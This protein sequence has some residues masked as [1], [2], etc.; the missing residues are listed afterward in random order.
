MSVRI[1]GL[2][3]LSAVA[4]AVSAADSPQSLWADGQNYVIERVILEKSDVFD[5]ADPEQDKWLYRLANRLHIITRDDTIMDQLLF[6]PGG[7]LDKR[8]LDESERILRTNKYLYD[9]NITVEKASGDTV[10]VRVHTRD[11]WSLQPE[12]SVSR[13]GGKTRTRF[14]LAETNLLGRGQQLRLLRDND[15]DRSENAIEFIDRNLGPSHVS[16]LAHHSDNSDGSRSQLNVTRP[17]FELDARWAAGGNMLSDDRRTPLYQFGEEAAEYRHRRDHFYLFAGRSNGLVRG[18]ARRWTAGIAF[19]DNRFS[20]FQDATLPAFI[21]PDRKLVYPFVGYQ[22]VEDEFVTT[23]NRDQIG[24]TEDFQMGLNLRAMLGWSD[25]SFGADRD[26]AIFLASASHGFGSLQARSL[27][28]STAT[29]GRVESG[30]LANAT[31][32]F[33]ARYYSKQSEKRTFFASASGTFGSNLDVD[34]P[35]EIGGKSGLRGY[36]LRYQVGDSRVLA[37]IEQRYYTDWYPFRFARVG[38]AIFADVGR[39]WGENPLGDD[40]RGWLADVGFGLRLAL[41]RLSAG[42]VLHIDLAFPLNNDP[43]IDDVQLL[44][45]LRDGF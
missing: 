31:F 17:F 3:C 4:G 18:R 15:V 44:I 43:E 21:P 10:N 5:L 12:L 22:L 41:T 6:E 45:E 23:R 16:L 19:D 30:D 2:A 20:E 29:N 7:V 26:A 1:A 8:R 28:L 35:V 25:T 9:A 32:S 40:N 24:R 38:G 34:N 27:F 39:A 14:G 13:R 36:P 33:S 11:V 42:R 37:T